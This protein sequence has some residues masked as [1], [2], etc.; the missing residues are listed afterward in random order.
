MQLGQGDYLTRV[1]ALTKFCQNP[2]PLQGF[3]V[4]DV[5]LQPFVFQFARLREKKES[6]AMPLSRDTLEY[7]TKIAKDALLEV[8]LNLPA[9]GSVNP[10]GTKQIMAALPQYEGAVTNQVKSFCK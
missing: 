3:T 5:C 9:G 1:A 7:Q 10:E 6:R 2:P 4:G 8:Q